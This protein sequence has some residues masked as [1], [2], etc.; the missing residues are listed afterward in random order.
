MRLLLSALDSAGVEA[1]RIRRLRRRMYSAAGPNFLWHIDGYDKV[2]PFGLCI[3]GCTD[4]FSRKI[5]WLNVYK[6]NSD[7][8]V[9]VGYYMTVIKRLGG[10]G[11]CGT[12]NVCIEEFQTYM[13]GGGHRH[14]RPVY[15]SGPSTANQRI[16]A[17]WGQLRKECIELWL[18]RLHELQES[19]NFCGDFR[20]LINMYK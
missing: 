16:E 17:F 19:D 7:P 14:G 6:T 18:A 10:C 11:D 1:R 2:K 9:V 12:E 15:I 13:L 20:D 5:M 8:N 4:A 3:H